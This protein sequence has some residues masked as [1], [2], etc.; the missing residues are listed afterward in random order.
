MKRHSE[1][2]WQ[3]WNTGIIASLYQKKQEELAKQ[4]AIIA[5]FRQHV[6]DVINGVTANQMTGA[7]QAFLG[8]SS[9]AACRLSATRR[10]AEHSNSATSTI[11]P[12]SM[13]PTST[14]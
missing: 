11:M 6:A 10:L 13:A 12:G 14:S 1:P 9:S 2:E 8:T 3:R 7:N 4:A 5:A